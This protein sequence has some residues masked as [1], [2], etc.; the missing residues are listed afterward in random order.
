MTCAVLNVCSIGKHDSSDWFISKMIVECGG[1]RYDL[2]L[3]QCLV[4]IRIH[5]EFINKSVW[6]NVSR[7]AN[8]RCSKK[9]VNLAGNRTRA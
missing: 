6:Q 8:C 9:Y 7:E 2:Y 1:S 5:L 3:N 4:M